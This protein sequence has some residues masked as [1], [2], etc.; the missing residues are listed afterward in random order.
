MSVTY[1]PAALRRLVE[2]RVNRLC[3]YC[4]LPADVSFF[5]DEVD[6]VIAEKHGGATNADNLVSSNHSNIA[7]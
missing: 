7:K 3:E 2:E 4:L 5:P 6:H 1:I